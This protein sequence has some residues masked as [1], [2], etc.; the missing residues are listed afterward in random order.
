MRE[1]LAGKK[2]YN[3]PVNMEWVYQEIDKGR[4]VKSVAEELQVSESTLRRRHHEYQS[5]LQAE[6]EMKLDKNGFLLPPE[7]L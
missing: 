6:E 7:S 5:Q 3:K 4:T 2:R 1:S